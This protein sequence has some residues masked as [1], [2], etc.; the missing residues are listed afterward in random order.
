MN[1]GERG[2]KVFTDKKDCYAFINL[3]KDCVEMWNIRVAAYCLMGTH[4]H[5]LLQT[6]DSNLSRCMR[7]INGVYT[8]YFKRNHET[9][10]EVQQRTY[11]ER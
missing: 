4:Y 5:V 3:L 7:H 11:L 8:Q 9:P 2:E 6:P 10:G 1:R